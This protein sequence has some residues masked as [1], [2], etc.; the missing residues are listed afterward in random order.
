MKRPEKIETQIE[1]REICVISGVDYPAIKKFTVTVIHLG[2]DCDD[3]GYIVN[4]NGQNRLLLSG[5]GVFSLVDNKP[6]RDTR[7]SIFSSEIPDKKK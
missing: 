2:W 3:V 1:T 4:I 7:L 6:R 5:Y